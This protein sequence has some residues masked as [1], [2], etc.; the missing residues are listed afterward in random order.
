MKIKAVVSYLMTFAVVCVAVMVSTWIVPV[1]AELMAQITAAGPRFMAVTM[2]NF[3]I[4]ALV[5]FMF[6]RVARTRGWRLALGM[7]GA[8]WG[9][10]YCMSQIESL[11]FNE[12]L[13]SMTTRDIIETVLR[14]FVSTALSVPAAMLMTGAFKKPAEKSEKARIALGEYVWKIPVGAVAYVAVYWLFGYFVAWQFPAVRQYYSGTA[15][16]IPFFQ[17]TAGVLS[18]SPT[19]LLIQ[20]GR[21]ALWGLLALLLVGLLG[22]NR[23]TSV[24]GVAALF[25]LF[26]LQLL[27]PNPMMPDAIRIPHLI[28]TASSML[29]YGAFLGSFLHPGQARLDSRQEA[30]AAR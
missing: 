25:V 26:G 9:V 29:L 3:A 5:L 6:L 7:V 22:R 24:A 15:N 1:R 28:E 30:H 10:L 11:I 2:V 16:L 17:Y 4:T 12:A 13:T 14:G 8:F 19:F 27:V 21:G 20:L 23:S 18:D